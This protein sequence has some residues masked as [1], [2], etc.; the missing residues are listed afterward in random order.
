MIRAPARRTLLRSSAALLLA[1]A[2]A[3]FCPE[4]PPGDAELLAACAAF[5]CAEGEVA[6]LEGIDDAPDAV[7]ESALDVLQAA[8]V[9]VSGLR[10][11]TASGVRAKAGVC[12][13]LLAMDEPDVRTM[14]IGG[15][16]RRHDALMWSLLADMA[17]TVA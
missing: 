9:R 16:T 15:A 8:I 17:E 10:A 6:R 11:R 3:S 4:L 5:G 12:R 13:V 14:R 2:A 1:G 7:F